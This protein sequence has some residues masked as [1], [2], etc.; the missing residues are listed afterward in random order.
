M[1]EFLQEAAEQGISLAL[2][3]GVEQSLP[4]SN[5]LELAKKEGFDV[6]SIQDGLSKIQDIAKQVEQLQVLVDDGLNTKNPT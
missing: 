6:S 4:L 5:P 1:Q 3:V 2:S